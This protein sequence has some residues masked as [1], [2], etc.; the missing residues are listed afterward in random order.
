M[1]FYTIDITPRLQYISAF[2]GK[3]IDADSFLLTTD[4]EEFKSYDGPKINYSNSKI[5]DGEFWLLPYSLLFEKDIRS[6]AIDCFDFNGQKAF[7]KTN[8]DLPFDFLAASF[9]L[10]SRYEEYLPHAKDIY[11][12]YAHGNSVA[13]KEGF[14]SIPQVNVWLEALKKKLKEKFPLFN[15]QYS[16]FNFLPTY[17]VDEA[18]SYKHKSW[19]R[20]LGAVSKAF[21]KGAWWKINERR[22]VLEEQ[23]QDPFDSYA[24]MDDLHERYKLK[25]RYFFLVPEKTGKYDRN[26]PPKET[27]LQGL[28]KQHADKYEIGVHPSWQSGNDLSLIKKEMETIENIS[29]KKSSISRQHFIRFTLPDT[30]RHLIQAGISDDYSMGYGSINGFRASI[31]TSFYWYDLEK[32]EQTSLLIHPFCFMDAN[33]FFEQKLSPEQ[34]LDEILSYYKK[35]KNVNGQMVTIWHNTF[36]G[37]D[38]MFKG[39][40]EVYEKFIRIV[41]SAY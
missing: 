4:I 7:F 34:A 21:L 13:F 37:T 19:D 9:Y 20:T 33:A 26:I 10:L 36:L 16:R 38:K 1:L 27:A 41:S 6:Q 39:W 32:E 30:Y 18:F 8:G 15:I 22:K 3:E 5:S 11:G 35:I 29:K 24:W 14:L 2:I 17:D 23:L 31:T 12:R 40:R 25:P 28:I